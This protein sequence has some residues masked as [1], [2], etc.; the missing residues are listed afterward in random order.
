MAGTLTGGLRDRMILES[1]LQFIKSDLS[2][3]GWFD[4]GR[5]HGPITVVDEY[6]DDREV[7][8]N[9]LAIS[10]GPTMQERAEMGSKAELHRQT[11]Y[12]DF[13][14]ES[15]ALG[16]HVIGDIYDNLAKNVLIPVYDYSLAT[17]VQ[18]FSVEVVDDSLEK[19]KPSSTNPWQRH[20]YIL[21]FIIEDDR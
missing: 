17:P 4:T 5:Q 8:L 12:V 3:R 6:P 10:Y 19:S 21:S 16:R 1:V 14:A 7:A 20:W 11:I 9:T 18:D 15:D 13:Y 2:A